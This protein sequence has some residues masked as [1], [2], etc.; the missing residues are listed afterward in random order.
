MIDAPTNVHVPQSKN[1]PTHQ[2]EEI[3]FIAF[4]SS[5]HP[6]LLI[7]LVSSSSVTRPLSNCKNIV[8]HLE[9]SFTVGSVMPRSKI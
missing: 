5:Y 8:K 2:L 9:L 6:Y 1:M 3:I 4:S 7:D